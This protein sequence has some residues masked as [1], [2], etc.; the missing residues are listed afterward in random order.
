MR[1]FA[2]VKALVDTGADVN[3]ACVNMNNKKII[4]DN[5]I[6]IKLGYSPLHYAVISKTEKNMT[7]NNIQESCL[8]VQFL[9]ASGADVN[10]HGVMSDV[11]DNLNVLQTLLKSTI[12]NS[13]KWISERKY[14]LCC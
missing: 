1:N 7:D 13:L 10:A 5:K 6:K 2:L 4:G 11:Y 8:I 14:Y 3:S 12:K 9:L